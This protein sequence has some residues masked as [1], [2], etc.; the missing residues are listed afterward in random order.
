MAHNW[1]RC[2]FSRRF[3]GLAGRTSLA[4]ALIVSL[5]TPA[6]GSEG[7]TASE[8]RG[9]ERGEL[10]VKTRDVEGYPW[11]EVRVYR[12]VEASPGEVMGAYVDF[13]SQV[14][15]LPHL[16][17]SRIVRRLSR[18]SFHVSYEYEVIGPNER[19]RVLAVVSR[20]PG[21]FQLTWELVTA[22]YARRLSGQ[23]RVEEASPGSIIEFANRV[24]P[25]FFGRLF[26]SPGTTV[27]RMRETVQALATYVE[28]LRAQRKEKLRALVLALRSMLDG[29]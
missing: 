20:S 18:N 5:L 25:G 29:P 11:P 8:R 26:G 2:A 27:R 16:A 15:Y 7:L 3:F 17:E 24:D 19:H 22:R 4:L 21:G 28:Q 14:G 12:W 1:V 23:M 9:L 13:E 10:I 6:R